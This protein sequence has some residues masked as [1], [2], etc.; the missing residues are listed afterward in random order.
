[1]KRVKFNDVLDIQIIQNRFQIKEKE[2]FYTYYLGIYLL[3]IFGSLLFLFYQNYP[4]FFLSLVL[5]CCIYLFSNQENLFFMLR[6]GG[7]GG[8]DPYSLSL[9]PQEIVDGISSIL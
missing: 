4:L 6:F 1:M 7:I 2:R 3:C 8:I 5:A 9:I